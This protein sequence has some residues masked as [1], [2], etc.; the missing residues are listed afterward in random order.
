MNINIRHNLRTCYTKL[1]LSRHKFLVERGR[2]LKPKIQYTDRKCTLCNTTDIE[3]EYHIVMI[4][5]NFKT[6][7]RTYLKKY[8]YN[9]PSMHKF[10]ELMNTVNRK[11]LFKLMLFIKIIFKEYAE[12]LK[13]RH[14]L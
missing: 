14:I 5:E 7:R 11:T 3:D 13:D 6:L 9:R 1:R 8:Y 4:C 2:W 10:V 12:T